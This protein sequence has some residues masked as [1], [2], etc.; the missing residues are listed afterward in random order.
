MAYSFRVLIISAL[1]GAKSSGMVNAWNAV[2]SLEDCFGISASA[3]S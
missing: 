2:A 1:E 3:C